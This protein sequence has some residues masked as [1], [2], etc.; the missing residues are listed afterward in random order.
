[1]DY[2]QRW[3]YAM[4]MMEANR[5]A[6]LEFTDC[7]DPAKDVSMV[8][9]S[10]RRLS[11]FLNMMCDSGLP[12]QIDSAC[13]LEESTRSINIRGDILQAIIPWGVVSWNLNVARTT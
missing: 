9:I 11:W 1:M 2:H 5:Y 10:L 13:A 4:V 12:F 8:S 6:T 7:N 3:T